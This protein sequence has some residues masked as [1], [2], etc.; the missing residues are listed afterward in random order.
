M[1]PM[2]R[3]VKRPNIWAIN[4]LNAKV[5]Q[6][7]GYIAI[8]VFRCCR[9]FCRCSCRCLLAVLYALSKRFEMFYLYV[10]STLLLTWLT[11]SVFIV[12]LPPSDKCTPIHVWLF[13][14]HITQGT[15]ECK[16]S[17]STFGVAWKFIVWMNQRLSITNWTPYSIPYKVYI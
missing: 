2:C 11:S 6:Q 4:L 9:C 5:I 13:M 1:R 16:A 3:Y 8:D 14:E 12:V 10:F 7:H 17:T 15:T